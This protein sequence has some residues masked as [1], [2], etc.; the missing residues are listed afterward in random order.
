M[1]PHDKTLDYSGAYYFHSLYNNVGAYVRDGLIVDTKQ[2]F[3]VYNDGYWFISTDEE[4]YC[5]LWGNDGGFFRLATKGQFRF[6]RFRTWIN[7]RSTVSIR[8]LNHL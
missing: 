3:L 2:T 1:N 4:K 7:L 6:S 8:L 5:F